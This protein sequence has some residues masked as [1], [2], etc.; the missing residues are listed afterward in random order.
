MHIVFQV[1]DPVGP[2]L[3]VNWQLTGHMIVWEPSKNIL[4]V[5]IEFWDASLHPQHTM[6]RNADAQSL[7]VQIVLMIG[8]A[9]MSQWNFMN[10]I[11]Q[12]IQ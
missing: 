12:E 11:F 10:W 9:R 1:L 2:P 5:K 8:A 4:C 3:A 7:A 6:I